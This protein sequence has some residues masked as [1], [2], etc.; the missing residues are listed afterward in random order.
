MLTKLQVYAINY[1]NLQDEEVPWVLLPLTPK[2][3]RTT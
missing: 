1:T 3:P 2:K